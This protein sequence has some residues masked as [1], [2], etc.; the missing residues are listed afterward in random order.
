MCEGHVDISYLALLCTT[1][2]SGKYRSIWVFI[3]LETEVSGT[4]VGLS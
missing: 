2:R 4:F 1:L 3:C